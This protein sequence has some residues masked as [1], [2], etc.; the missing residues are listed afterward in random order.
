MLVGT[1]VQ[2]GEAYTDTLASWGAGR[3]QREVCTWAAWGEGD[4]HWGE[5]WGDMQQLVV[6]R[7]DTLVEEH[8]LLV[9]GGQE[10]EGSQV[11]AWGLGGSS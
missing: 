11:E 8:I 10:Q 1:A 2:V 9:V 5:V 4:R 3:V 6:V 7:R